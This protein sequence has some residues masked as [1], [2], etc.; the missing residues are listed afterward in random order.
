MSFKTDHLPKTKEEWKAELV[1]RLQLSSGN[2][3]PIGPNLNQVLDLMAHQLQTNQET[4]ES[5]MKSIQPAPQ[6]TYKEIE[7]EMDSAYCQYIE[8]YPEADVS[9]LTVMISTSDFR[10]LED[11]ALVYHRDRFGVVENQPRL[12][13]WSTRHAPWGFKLTHKE[14]L[15]RMVVIDL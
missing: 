12:A 1:H 4:F 5:F 2:T 6:R 8:A 7:A 14:G 10:I 3:E 9:K 15:E 13:G 11:Q